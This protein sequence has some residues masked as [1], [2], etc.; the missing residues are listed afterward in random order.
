[1]AIR[2]FSGGARLIASWLESPPDWIQGIA[3]TYPVVPALTQVRTRVVVTRVGLEHPQIQATV[4]RL[5]AVAPT[6][7][8]IE[9]AGRQHGFDMLDHNDDSRHAVETAR[10]AVVR[11][12]G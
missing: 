1:V 8:V 5:L 6:A 11:L 4:D 2:A 9:V 3:L 7:E 12:L 10:D